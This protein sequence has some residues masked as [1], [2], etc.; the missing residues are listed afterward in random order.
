MAIG[1]AVGGSNWQHGTH[2]ATSS[3][4]DFTDNMVSVDF[5]S[6]SERIPADV[7][8]T[9]FHIYENG[10]K[11]VPIIAVYKCNDTVEG[12]LWDIHLNDD[13]VNWQLGPNGITTGKLKFTGTAQIIS[14]SAPIVVNQIEQVTVEFA[15]SGAV[16]KGAF[17]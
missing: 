5:K 17:A 1:G 9:G 13:V 7:W 8:N 4:T 2:G 16:T 6:S 14:I 3:L 12:Q 15:M 11:D 10:F